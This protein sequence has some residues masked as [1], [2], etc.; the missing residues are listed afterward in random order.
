MHKE[1]VI[2]LCNNCIPPG[3]IIESQWTRDGIHTE[4]KILPC[5]GKISVQYLL[6]AIEGGKN[7]ICIIA[8]PLGDCSFFQGNYRA[9]VRIE[10]VKRLLKEI[11]LEPD[12]VRLIHFSKESK[13]EE[14]KG[15]IRDFVDSIAGTGKAQ[16]GILQ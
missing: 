2:F 14:L 10:N 16:I 8:C 13:E 11:G 5:S 4:L 9:H 12:M 15:A 3:A 7:G 6:H 1:I